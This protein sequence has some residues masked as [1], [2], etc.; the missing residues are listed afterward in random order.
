MKYIFLFVFAMFFINVSNV[1]A[2]HTDKKAVQTSSQKVT[3]TVS[4][5]TCQK[6]CADGI[7][8]KLKSTK[9]IVRSKTLL[10]TG[11]SNITYNPAEISLEDIVAIIKDRGYTAAVKEE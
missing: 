7:D 1:A 3:L 5:M 4:G 6:G 9:G 8:K 2:Q 11:E 10:S